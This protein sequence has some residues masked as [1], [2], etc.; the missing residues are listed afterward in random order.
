M[1]FRYSTIAAIALGGSSVLALDRAA[2]APPPA[3]AP[4]G[5]SKPSLWTFTYTSSSSPTPIVVRLCTSADPSFVLG[6]TS[7]PKVASNCSILSRTVAPDG[8]ITV[9]KECKVVIDKDNGFVFST[10]D[11]VSSDGRRMRR[12][13]EERTEPPAPPPRDKLGWSDSTEVYV[14]EC[15]VPLPADQPFVK[16][17]PDGRAVA[18]S[19]LDCFR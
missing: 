2:S 16:I 8:T 4:P 1:G 17:E 12:R 9:D 18:C 11:E 14:G 7:Q 19:P 6:V 3:P 5:E 13:F 10:H 15:P